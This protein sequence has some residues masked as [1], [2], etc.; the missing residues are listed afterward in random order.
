M[1]PGIIAATLLNFTQDLSK[2]FEDDSIPENSIC[3]CSTD[4]MVTR[5]TFSAHALVDKKTH[6][7]VIRSLAE[8]TSWAVD[9]TTKD[10]ADVVLSFGFRLT[11]F[12]NGD[13]IIVP[14]CSVN[15]LW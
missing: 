8:L 1:A 4:P 13:S 11:N 14:T 9:V 7:H 2:T 6:W 12:L 3:A 15:G 5:E 10:V